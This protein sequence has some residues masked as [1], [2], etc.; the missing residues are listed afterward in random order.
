MD[1]FTEAM[2]VT[3]IDFR[4]EKPAE[5][6]HIMEKNLSM[7]L[8]GVKTTRWHIINQRLLRDQIK[9]FKHKA[10]AYHSLTPSIIGPAL[11]NI[12][13]PHSARISCRRWPIQDLEI[14]KNDL[15]PALGSSASGLFV[16]VLKIKKFRKELTAVL[17]GGEWNQYLCF[18]NNIPTQPQSQSPGRILLARPQMS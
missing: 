6:Q 16:C 18:S 12:T 5:G 13:L 14:H 11:Q 9:S 4:S 15:H 7:W 1:S 17:W 8:P 3:C 2:D 10:L